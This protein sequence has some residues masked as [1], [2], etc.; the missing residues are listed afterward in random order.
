MLQT[1]VVTE[2]DRYAKCVEASKRIRWEIDKDVIRGREFDFLKKF[3]PDGLA[4]IEGFSSLSGEEKRL[5]SQIQGRTYANVFGLVERF[6]GVK[7]MEVSRDYWLGDQVAL[8]ALVRFTDEELKHQELFR[9]V[10]QMIAAGIPDGYTFVAEPNTVA[11]VV[12]QKSTWAVLGLTCDIELVTQAHYKQ[13]IGPDENLSELFKDIFLY[14]WREEAQHATL[15]ELEWQREDAK[16]TPDDR[17]QAVDDLIALVAAI[18]DILQAQSAADAGYF[19][20]ICGRPVSA[21]EMEQITQG[22]LGAYR[23]QYIFSGVQHPRFVQILS[24]M[25]TESQGQRI[26]NALAPLAA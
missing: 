21:E 20:A 14:H 26:A 13:S 3:L 2:T 7:V 5:I 1:A 23:W 10:D 15:D 12:L 11:S 4:K 8:E 22:L 18:D 9:R 25:I 24:G 16:L 19:A 6:I 17:D